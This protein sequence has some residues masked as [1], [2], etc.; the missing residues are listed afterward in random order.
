MITLQISL[1]PSDYRH[2]IH[3]LAHQIKVFE[4]QVDEILLTYDTHKSKGHFSNNWEL[5]IDKMWDFLVDFSKS[6]I[7]IRL[8]KIDYSKS[9]N[10]E[11]AQRYFRR[12][13]I[14]AKDWRGGPFYTYFFGINEAKNNYVFHIDSDLFFGGMSKSWLEQ[15]LKL[16]KDDEQILFINPLAG[17]P[18]ADG[19]LIG[20]VYSKYKNKPF[21]FAFKSMS[22]RLFLI[23]KDRLINFKLDNI[24]TR[25][26]VHFLKAIFRGNPPFKLPEEILSSKLES[27]QMLRVDFMG[28][29]PGL[30]SLHP[31]YRTS[32]FYDNLPEIINRI[33]LNDFPESQKG[34]YDIVDEFVDWT[35]AKSKLKM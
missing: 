2:A 17:P 30:W 19:E 5:N 33:E 23:N 6:N 24:R 28:N 4:E 29:E 15:A 9:K 13:N 27:N 12:K 3:L 20:Q 26:I 35:E 25:N 21:Y 22:T 8:I 16:Y 18:K 34:F 14:P 1:A 32:G 7:K 11:I 10:R 31:P